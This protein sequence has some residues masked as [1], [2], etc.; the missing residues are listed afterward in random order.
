[1]PIKVRCKQCS[2]VLT[3]SDKAR[4]RAVRCKE[5]GGRVQVGSGRKKTPRRETPPTNP[6]DLFSGLNLRAAADAG[7][8]I[9]PSCATPAR[10][11]EEETCHKC[12]VNIDT[13]KLA[14]KERLRR[15]RNAPP[16]EEF[17]GTVFRD[18]IDFVKQNRRWM[19]TSSIVW[20]MA[21]T[22]A[23]SAAFTIDWYVEGREIELRDSAAGMIEV[24]DDY[25]LI[26]LNSNPESGEARY[27]GTRYT[28]S[29][30]GPDNRLVFHGPRMG[31]MLSP[32]AVFWFMI[33]FL[34]VLGFGGWAWMLAIAIA[35]TTFDGSSE[36]K[37][38]N[39]DLFACMAMGF[40]SIF[41]PLVLLWPFL[42]IPPL[43]QWL[44][45]NVIVG[46]ILWACI[47]LLP[48]AVFLPAA[49]VHLT[50]KYTYRAWLLDWM[51]LAW[52]KTAV[53]SS[54]VSALLVGLVLAAP[55][56]CVVLGLVFYDGVTRFYTT[57]IEIPAL[58]ALIGYTEAD[59][60]SFGMFA[61]LRLPFLCAVTFTGAFV[62]CGVMSFPA[63]FV[64]RA[65]GT[66]GVFFRPEL[67]LINEQVDL[68]PA[69]FG[70][71]FLAGLIDALLLAVIAATALFAATMVTKLFG[72]LYAFPPQTIQAAQ[73]LIGGVCTLA[74]W[75]LY[76]ATWE[77]GQ[78]RG[79]LGKA[80][81]G[82]MVLRHD[83]KPVDSRLSVKRAGMALISLLTLGLGFAMCAFQ[84]DRRALHD[85]LSKT[86]VV[87]R[88]ESD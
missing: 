31:A 40:R 34:S 84:A 19:I 9:C 4:G 76:Y 73:L 33:L 16:P 55:L 44:T 10:D 50:Q 22:M 43:V 64:M 2:T 60:A 79:T 29:A 87:W 12:G 47:F 58:S 21:L 71:R 30:M 37:R 1:M 39:F 14:E 57:S 48:I 81:I 20:A 77:A 38:F 7:T 27:D 80:S 52:V 78:N 67:S 61:F 75:G 65:I 88:E 36:L 5:C 82:I 15:K 70:P 28:K 41:W 46:S 74:V 49:I 13:G 63:L 23:A 6:D 56:T 69:G 86:K 25:V 32:P 85:I 26:D 68:E 62:F 53:P 59:E 24:T 51:S 18:G 54:F 42:W 66:F 11:D 17:Y 35:K 83:D 45:G 3:V 72:F 8:R